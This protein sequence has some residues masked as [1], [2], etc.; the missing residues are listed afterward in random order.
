MVV[1]LDKNMLPIYIAPGVVHRF[2]CAPLSC[3]ASFTRLCADTNACFASRF[4]RLEAPGA[5]RSTISPDSLFERRFRDLSPFRTRP[6]RFRVKW[7]VRSR[8]IVRLIARMVPQA[9]RTPWNFRIGI[10]MKTMD[11]ENWN[12]STLNIEETHRTDNQWRYD[13]ISGRQ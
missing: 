8:E 11:T 6:L 2:T 10:F 12:T 4:A 7:R 3:R 1:P 9:P 5:F 13:N